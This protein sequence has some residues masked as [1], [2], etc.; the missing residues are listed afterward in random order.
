MHFLLQYKSVLTITLLD[1]TY[2]ESNSRACSTDATEPPKSW[3]I[4]AAFSTKAA[5]DLAYGA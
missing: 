5:F 4:L 1:Q 3:I 2:N